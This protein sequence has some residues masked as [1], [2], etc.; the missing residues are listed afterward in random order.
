MNSLLESPPRLASADDFDFL[1]G[2]WS[3]T[4]RRLATRLA[5]DTRWVE[6]DGYTR[7][8]R[9]LGG[10]GNFDQNVIDLPKG[11]YQACTLR[12]FNP[13]TRLWTIHWIDGRDPKLDEPVTGGFAEGV[14]TFYGDDVLDGR[15]IRVRFRWSGITANS[16][17]W[18]QAFSGDDGGSW[19]TNWTMAFQ[20]SRK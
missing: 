3:V 16:A 8:M 9:I 12:L 11:G 14:G 10:L 18:E 15:P 19:E 13:R 17:H 6:F 20:R 1:I 4:H 5:G 7:V 2:D